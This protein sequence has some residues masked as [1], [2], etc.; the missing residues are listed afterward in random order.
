MYL[1][2]T[3]ALIPVAIS[4]LYVNKLEDDLKK[5]SS[6][7]GSHHATYLA[8]YEVDRRSIYVGNLPHNVENIEAIVRFAAAKVGTV[9]NVQIIRKEPRHGELIVPTS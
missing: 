1:L 4:L 7:Q 8:R 6:S 2:N 3:N 5:S 9:E